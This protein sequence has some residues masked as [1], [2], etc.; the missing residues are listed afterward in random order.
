MKNNN[1]SVL[2]CN[3]EDISLVL[4]THLSIEICF[5]LV[6]RAHKNARRGTFSTRTEEK[7]ILTQSQ[8]LTEMPK[9]DQREREYFICSL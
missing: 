2:I 8:N 5:I 7:H 6:D 3:I 4:K 9:R 1:I